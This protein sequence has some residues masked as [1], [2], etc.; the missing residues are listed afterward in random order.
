[1]VQ[2]ISALECA[3]SVPSDEK[4]Y[5]WGIVFWTLGPAALGAFYIGVFHNSDLSILLKVPE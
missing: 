5:V 2:T 1:V 3:S 4:V